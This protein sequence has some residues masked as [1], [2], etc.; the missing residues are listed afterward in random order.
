MKTDTVMISTLITQ[1]EISNGLAQTLLST[2]NQAKTFIAVL[3]TITGAVMKD[4]LQMNL[5]AALF[6][7]RDIAQL[8]A[9]PASSQATAAQQANTSVKLIHLA[10]P[11]KLLAVTTIPKNGVLILMVDLANQFQDT[12]AQMKLHGVIQNNMKSHQLME[13][14]DQMDYADLIVVMKT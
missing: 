11:M 12:V 7:Q 8:K 9:M 3:Q 4:V 10:Y 2:V 13:K 1:L 5:N 6:L 14:Q